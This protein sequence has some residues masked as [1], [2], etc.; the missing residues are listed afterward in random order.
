MTLQQKIGRAVDRARI[1]WAIIAGVSFV[2]ALINYPWWALIIWAV[3][4]V[5][6]YFGTLLFTA[7]I[8][9]ANITEEE[10]Q[11]AENEEKAK[12]LHDRI[13][14]N[15]VP[16]EELMKMMQDAGVTELVEVEEVGPEIGRY[17]DNP[18][19]AYVL[20]KSPGSSELEKF[21]YHGPANMVHGVPEIPV[22]DGMLFAHIEGIIYSREQPAE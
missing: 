12:D 9:A 8:L 4:A 19:Y 7:W 21:L 17:K 11:Q 10:L 22:I 14:A 15:Q 16:P 6:T 20:M 3:L 1:S 13:K 18:I 5:F 2:Y